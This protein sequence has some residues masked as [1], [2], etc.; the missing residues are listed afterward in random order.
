MKLLVDCMPLRSGGGLQVAI[1]FIEGLRQQKATQWLAIV[2][3]SMMEALPPDFTFDDAR[4]KV[5]PKSTTWDIV[6]ARL[7]LQRI[8]REFSPD[9]VFTVFGPAYFRPYAPHL[10]GF[11]LPNLIY[12][13]GEIFAERTGFYDNAL[14]WLR[15]ALLRRADHLVVETETV[16]Q[17][18]ANRLDILA[19]KISVIRNGVNPHLKSSHSDPCDSNEPPFGILVPSAYYRHKNLEIIPSVAA[20][21]KALDP[22]FDFEF[23]L[24]LPSTSRPWLRIHQDSVEK[25]VGARVITLGPQ[26][27]DQLPSAYGAASAVFLPTLC[28]ASTAVYP[29]SFFFRRPL[30]TSDMDF[31]QELC[32]DAA[33]F[34]PPR[35]PEGIAR[36][37]LELHRS[38]ALTRRL[39]KNGLSRLEEIYLQPDEKF[40]LQMQLISSLATHRA[41]SSRAIWD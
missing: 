23:R 8:E 12:D 24:M 5:L 22:K 11:A 35:D 15:C 6:C 38:G 40:A 36:T 37:F 2:P 20:A 25:R 10:V 31:A 41:N 21:L 29:E 1:A 7:T 34:V 27:I 32:G 17:R 28:E 14:N 18:L 9:V 3:P 26:R 39:V 4:L 33:L 16:R 19:E 30:I 13:P